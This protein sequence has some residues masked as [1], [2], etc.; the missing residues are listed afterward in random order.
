MVDSAE[1]FFETNS[2]NLSAK[3]VS[4]LD[5]LGTVLVDVPN[6]ISVEGHADHRV[7]AAPFPTNWELSSARAIAV[8]QLMI[9]NGL[10]A[11]RV[12]ATAFGEFQPLDTA[13]TAQAR[14]RNRRIEL[15]LTDR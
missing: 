12:A 7:A 14:A 10:P 3:A 8:A 9:Q 2:T 15:R 6:E 11:N 13:D 5:T 4:V 1:T